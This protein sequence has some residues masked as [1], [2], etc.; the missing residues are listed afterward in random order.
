MRYKEIIFSVDKQI[1]RKLPEYTMKKLAWYNIAVDSKIMMD[2]G[3]GEVLGP[4]V[5]DTCYEEKFEVNF[6]V[7]IDH[8]IK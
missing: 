4:K 6:I 1:Y 7:F 2:K 8:K 3:T 5:D